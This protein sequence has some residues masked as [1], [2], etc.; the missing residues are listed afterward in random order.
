M[1]VI[2]QPNLYKKRIFNGG[3]LEI[4]GFIEQNTVCSG[5]EVKL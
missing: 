4:M 5:Y 1:V 2:I 3:D